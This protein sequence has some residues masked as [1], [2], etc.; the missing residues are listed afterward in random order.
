MTPVPFQPFTDRLSRDIRNTLSE[1]LLEA[2]QEQTLTP[3]RAVAE[4]FLRQRP[5]EAY[6]AYI[7]ERLKRYPYRLY[8]LGQPAF[9]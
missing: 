8:T 4:K 3:A 9:L 2:I 5:D 1:S 7:D 6:V